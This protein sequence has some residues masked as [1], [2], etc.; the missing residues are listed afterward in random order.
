[1]RALLLG[2][3]VLWLSACGSTPTGYSQPQ[4]DPV[5]VY[6]VNIDTGETLVPQPG[7]GYGVFVEYATGGDWHVFTTC[8]ADVT[9]YSCAWDLIASVDA[10]ET[11]KVTDQTELEAPDKVLPI[12]GSAVRLVFQTDSD[13]DGVHLS[14]TAGEPLSLDIEWDGPF[15]ASSTVSWF[16][17]GAV[18][19]GAPSDP[20][21]LMPT[22]P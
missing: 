17:E 12:N 20:V 18:H 16:G 21:D 6:S 1:M 9:G 4:G 15:A 3:S 22:A 11:L 5:H 14:G 19:T 8:D 13:T 2:S 7:Q 10:T